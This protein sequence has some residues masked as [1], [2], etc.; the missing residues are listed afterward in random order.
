MLP[1]EE[2][3]KCVRQKICEVA[4]LLQSPKNVTIPIDEFKNLIP[5]DE[6][7]LIFKKLEETNEIKIHQ[8]ASYVGK[9]KNNFFKGI[10]GDLIDNSVLTSFPDNSNYVIDVLTDSESDENIVTCGYL[11]LNLSSQTLQ[12]KTIKPIE[13]VRNNHEITMLHLL[14]QGT[15]K[16]ISYEEIAECIDLNSYSGGRDK[17]LYMQH[18]F[19][20]KNKLK[21]ILISAGVDENEVDAMLVSKKGVGY[22]IIGKN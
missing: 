21:K 19:K 5:Y 4:K 1:T 15:P 10:I 22:K 18:I 20:L 3:L 13:I 16:V 17:E 9:N 6:V 12:Y 8:Y 2:K 14:M 11:T 7:D